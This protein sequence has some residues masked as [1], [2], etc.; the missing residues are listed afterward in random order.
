MDYTV[1]RD[2]LRNFAHA[3]NRCLL[4]V[5]KANGSVNGSYELRTPKTKTPSITMGFRVLG[6]RISCFAVQLQRAVMPCD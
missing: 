2:T 5:V 1:S 6:G 4:K 3:Q